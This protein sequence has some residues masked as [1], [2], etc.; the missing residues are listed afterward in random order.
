[1]NQLYNKARERYLSA[2][3]NW[4]IGAAGLAL[5]D[6]NYLFDPAHEFLIQ[7]PSAS[8]AAEKP[9]T[10]RTAVNGYA[11]GDGASFT[12]L[13]WPLPITQVV[14]YEDT[15][16]EATSLLIAYYDE[17]TGFPVS[18]TGGDYSVLPDALFGG[19]FRL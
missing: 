18:L 2:G 17:V 3:S 19:Y 16:D 9:F 13:T 4:T 7:V 12:A 11:N 14:T 6:A 15:G 8:R 1:M 10:G 5:V